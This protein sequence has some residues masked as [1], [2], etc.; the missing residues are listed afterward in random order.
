MMK[1]VEFKAKIQDQKISLPVNQQELKDGQEVK[2]IV[3]IQEAAEGESF[4]ELATEHFVE[5]YAAEDSMY[6]NY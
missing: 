3:L 1:A 6:D 4:K 2:V 5:G